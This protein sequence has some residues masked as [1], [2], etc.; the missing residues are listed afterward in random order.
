MS[1]KKI[2]FYNY[3][4]G[5]FNTDQTISNC[6][7]STPCRKA[8]LKE[9]MLTKK[10]LFFMLRNWLVI[11]SV[12]QIITNHTQWGHEDKGKEFPVSTLQRVKPESMFAK[13]KRIDL[14][15]WIKKKSQMCSLHRSYVLPKMKSIL[16]M[17]P[18]LVYSYVT[19]TIASKHFKNVF[20]QLIS[21]MSL[22]LLH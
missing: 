4:L 3:N 1:L 19:I 12:L 13:L 9:G 8:S 17:Y 10:Q 5:K 14:N 7:Y 6:K 22:I 16:R 18:W 2:G 21:K 11:F 20:I 15:T